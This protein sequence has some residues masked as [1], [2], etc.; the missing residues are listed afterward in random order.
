MIANNP[1]QYMAY[2]TRILQ[3]GLISGNESF[4]AM[5]SAIKSG[6]YAE[7]SR[8]IYSEKDYNNSRKISKGITQRQRGS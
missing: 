8:K 6:N 2:S 3:D 7:Y 5:L 1:G 4:A